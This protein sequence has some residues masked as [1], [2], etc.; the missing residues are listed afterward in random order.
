M[1]LEA[2]DRPIR[3]QLA[4]GRE[5]RL[6]PG[7]PV[8]LPDRQGRTL[9]RKARGKVLAVST[10]DPRFHLAES[11]DKQSRTVRIEFSS[12]GRGSKREMP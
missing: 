7:H 12:T 11:E 3:Y 1:L 8:D 10:G 5:V 6:A 9:L 4:D 2:V